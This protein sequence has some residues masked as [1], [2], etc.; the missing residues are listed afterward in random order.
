MAWLANDYLGESQVVPTATPRADSAWTR[1]VLRLI[2]YGPVSAECN[3]HNDKSRCC[4]VC[5]SCTRTISESITR[6]F[7]RSGRYS[8]RPG[9]LCITLQRSGEEVM[10]HRRLYVGCNSCRVWI[11][12]FPDRRLENVPFRMHVNLDSVRIWNGIAVLS[13]GGYFSED[14]RIHLYIILKYFHCLTSTSWRLKTNLRCTSFC[15]GNMTVAAHPKR[16]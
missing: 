6:R 8:C 11:G 1:P 4:L 16:M 15:F 7:R 5:S 10:K 12:C 13:H 14:F 2:Q 3:L 9:R